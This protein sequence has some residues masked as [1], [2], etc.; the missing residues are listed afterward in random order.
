MTFLHFV[1]RE[2]LGPPREA[3]SGFWHCPVC[4]PEADKRDA[5]FWANPDRTEFVCGRCDWQGDV[6]AFV[7]G[8]CHLPEALARLV[9]GQL[10][11]DYCEG[12]HLLDLRPLETLLGRIQ[13]ADLQR[14]L[15]R[16]KTKVPDQ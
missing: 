15:L 5:Q 8:F 1:V 2:L 6:L 10:W 12:H 4:D 7:Q 3:Y 9:L 16:S 14:Y 13:A 11:A